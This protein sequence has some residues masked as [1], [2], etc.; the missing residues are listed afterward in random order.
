M[1]K[2]F[3]LFLLLPSVVCG[4]ERKMPNLTK[5]PHLDIRQ[6][7]IIPVT[8]TVIMQGEEI[9]VGAWLFDF[10]TTIEVVN[11]GKSK[12]KDLKKG[13]YVI[14][15]RPKQTI[16]YTILSWG[17]QNDKF[18][19]KRTVYVAKDEEEKKQFEKLAR[20]KVEEYNRALRNGTVHGMS[21]RS[22]KVK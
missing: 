19:F 6:N 16:T 2:L 14:K 20:Q 11:F 9:E 21:V 4:Q 12:K 10:M 22:S 18:S 15:Q 8:D 17:D 1:K 5:G 13:Y 7:A 3:L